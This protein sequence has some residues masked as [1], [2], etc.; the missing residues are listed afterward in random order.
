M[1]GILFLFVMS[2][3]SMQV[4]LLER[5]ATVPVFN[6]PSYHTAKSGTVF[7]LL[8]HGNAS[9]PAQNIFRTGLDTVGRLIF[10]Y[11]YLICNACVMVAHSGSHRQEQQCRKIN[12]S[13][14]YLFNQ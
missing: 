12:I 11:R 7:D 5:G 10:L 2:R 3:H 14:I 1:H 4:S 8:N 9:L 13:F 6:T